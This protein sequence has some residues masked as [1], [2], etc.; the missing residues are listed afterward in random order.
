M[1]KIKRLEKSWRIYGVGVIMHWVPLPAMKDVLVLDRCRVRP[2]A[3]QAAAG[4]GTVAALNWLAL[5][6]ACSLRATACDSLRP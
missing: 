4:Y 3:G 6:T 2:A 1:L 5:L